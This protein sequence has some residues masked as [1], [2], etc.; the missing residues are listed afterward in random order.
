MT[1]LGFVA[2]RA[3]S[4]HPLHYLL[5]PVRLICWV[6]AVLPGLQ[7]QLVLLLPG[8]KRSASCWDDPD[9]GQEPG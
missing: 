5:L 6:V 7:L 1:A 9:Q 4:R 3:V 2:A 8:V